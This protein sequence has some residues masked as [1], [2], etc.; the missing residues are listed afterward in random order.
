MSNFENMSICF[1]CNG[2]NRSRIMNTISDLTG[3]SDTVEINV[4]RFSFLEVL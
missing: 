4:A 3:V 1:I 2:N